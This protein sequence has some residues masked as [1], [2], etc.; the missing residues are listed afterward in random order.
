VSTTYNSTFHLQVLIT[1][2]SYVVFYTKQQDH[3][4]STNY[5]TVTQENLQQA[6]VFS[7][8]GGIEEI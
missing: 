5:S 8:P 2:T 1:G 6:V 7:L 4:L 3:L